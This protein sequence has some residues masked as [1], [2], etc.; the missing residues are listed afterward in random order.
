MKWPPMSVTCCLCGATDHGTLSYLGRKGWDWFTG[1]GSE[2]QE[3]CRE[4]CRE[5]KDEIADRAEQAGVWRRW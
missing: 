5:R 1:R 2:R 3:F 4:C